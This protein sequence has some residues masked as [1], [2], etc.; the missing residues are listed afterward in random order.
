MS[1]VS[2][3]DLLMGGRFTNT[4]LYLLTVSLCLSDQSVTIQSTPAEMEETKEFSTRGKCFWN[5]KHFQKLTAGSSFDK[6]TS[7]V[8]LRLEN[9]GWSQTRWLALFTRTSAQTWRLKKSVSKLGPQAQQE[10]AGPGHSFPLQE[11]WRS[12]GVPISVHARR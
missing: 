3:K 4:C 10:G 6:K 2:S 8:L 5:F 11:R 12:M 7:A 9:S 1:R